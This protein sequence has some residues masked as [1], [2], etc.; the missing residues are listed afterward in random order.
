MHGYLFLLSFLFMIPLNAATIV[1]VSKKSRLVKVKLSKGESRRVIKGDEILLKKRGSSDRAKGKVSYLKGRDAV[2][3]II[4]GSKDWDTKDKVQITSKRSTN[5][6]KI[7]GV[8][9]S[10]KSSAVSS[11]RSTR[12]FSL[13]PE[14]GTSVFPVPAL[15]V[16]GGYQIS[17]DM[18]VELNYAHGEQ[19]FGESQFEEDPFGIQTS[20]TTDVVS[21]RVKK[22][23]TP[24]IYTNSGLGYRDVTFQGNI[25][26]LNPGSGV[27]LDGLSEG[28]ELFSASRKDVVLDLAAGSQWSYNQMKF[29]V[30]LIGVLLPVASVG[31]KP[32]ENGEVTVASSQNGDADNT[33]NYEDYYEYDLPGASFQAKA[34]FGVFF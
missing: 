17:Q 27:T 13:L 8:K 5:W 1:K 4:A 15:G 24:M 28:D 20:L 22:F 16:T 14:I 30:D 31:S 19:D 23:W 9:K 21:A 2:V 11:T 18:H 3:T 10:S 26:A 7:Y 25:G 12:S 6:R 33:E 32:E 34:Y 29:G